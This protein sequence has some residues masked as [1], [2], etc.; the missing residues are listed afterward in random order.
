MAVTSDGTNAKLYIDGGLAD[1]GTVPFFAALAGN[2]GT[3]A[4]FEIGARAGAARWKGSLGD[5]RIYDEVLNQAAI[6]YISSPVHYGDNSLPSGT[7]FI[8]R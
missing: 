7:V 2:M 8:V 6:T 5:V 4:T 3:F 1:T